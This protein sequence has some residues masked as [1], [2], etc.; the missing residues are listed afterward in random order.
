[1]GVL[2]DTHVDPDAL[3]GILGLRRRVVLGFDPE[4]GEPLAREFLFH[5]DLF[6]RSTVG[7]LAVVDQQNSA[8]LYP[9][10]TRSLRSFVEE[11]ALA[12]RFS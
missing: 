4:D 11:G 6:D 5:D 1:M 7:N 10:P 9:L 2:Q 12:P 8:A 3:L